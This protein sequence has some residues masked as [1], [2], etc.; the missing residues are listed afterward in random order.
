MTSPDG[1]VLWGDTAVDVEGRMTVHEPDIADQRSAFDLLT[2]RDVAVRTFV[3]VEP[4]K[5]RRRERPD[6]REAR[7]GY[8]SRAAP[9]P[10]VQT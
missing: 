2:Y 7:A 6:G 9:S 3:F 5:L 10:S 1:A 4:P 8:L